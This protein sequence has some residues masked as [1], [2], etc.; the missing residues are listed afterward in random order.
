MT[1]HQTPR[2]CPTT[3]LPRYC[4]LCMLLPSVLGAVQ[5][6]MDFW[7]YPIERANAYMD[8]GPALQTHLMTILS[9][10][11]EPGL[12]LLYSRTGIRPVHVLYCSGKV[13]EG[14]PKSTY[15]L[16]THSRL[17]QTTTQTTSTSPRTLQTRRLRWSRARLPGPF[18]C[19]SRRAPRTTASPAALAG[20]RSFFPTTGAWRPR[21]SSSRPKP[22]SC[23]CTSTVTI[24]CW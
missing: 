22:D 2:H 15:K 6:F 17:L 7:S 1:D 14:R 16:T 24:A 19:T 13:A 11:H 18:C 9:T 3:F 4:F 20:R 5:P 8:K 23:C 10:N 21:R 12:I